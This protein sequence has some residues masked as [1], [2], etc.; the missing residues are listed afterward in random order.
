MVLRRTYEGFEV[1]IPLGMKLLGV[2]GYPSPVIV[3]MRN[4]SLEGLS[5]ELQEG[6]ESAHL[7]PY[8]HWIKR[9]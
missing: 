9:G 1:L 4:T 3:E 2:F 8:W 7:I 6:E 5:I